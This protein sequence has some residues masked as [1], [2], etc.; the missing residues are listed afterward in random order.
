MTTVNIPEVLDL[1]K[2]VVDSEDKST[3]YPR[4]NLFGIVDHMGSL[5][6]GH[7]TAKCKNSDNRRWYEFNDSSVHEISV[8]FPL[9][10][11]SAYILFYARD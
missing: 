2:L 3:Q 11:S 7:Y 9:S 4:Y 6:G 5:N 10:S 8:H 1:S